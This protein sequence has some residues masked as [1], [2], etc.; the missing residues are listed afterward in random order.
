[1]QY[2]KKI[3]FT[4]LVI[5]GIISLSG[6]KRRSRELGIMKGLGYT[7]KDLMT[8][9]AMGIIPVT[10]ISLIIAS[11]CGVI[12]NKLFWQILFGVVMNTNV[13]ILIITDVVMILFC[14]IVTYIGARRIRKISVNELITE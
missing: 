3:G 11:V 13:P 9:V 2:L 4:A 8:Q 7:S 1:M 10:I 14:Y 12:I 5:L 6:V